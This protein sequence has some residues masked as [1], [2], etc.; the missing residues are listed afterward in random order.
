MVWSSYHDLDKETSL[1]P[2]PGYS[3]FDACFS[4]ARRAIFLPY[5]ID[6]EGS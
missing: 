2:G 6:P 5:D 4:A 3:S 1:T